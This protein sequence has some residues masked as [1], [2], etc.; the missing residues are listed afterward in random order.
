M[1]WSD[2][3]RNVP[4]PTVEE[5]YHIR[6]LIERQEKRT[7]DRNDYREREKARLERMSELRDAKPVTITDFYCGT[8]R[9][10]FKSHAVLHVEH[11]WTCAGQLLAFYKAKCRTCA[12]W[13]MRLVLDKYRD[14]FYYRSR[15][16][17]LDQGKHYADTVQPHE[18]GFNLLYGKKL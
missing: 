2:P 13:S 7:A 17:K 12:T 6:Q 18:T 10:D 9:K 4:K 1:S 3:L 15:A 11:D 8:C 16:V 14:V 5:H